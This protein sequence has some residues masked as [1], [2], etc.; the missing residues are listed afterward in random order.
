MR[1]NVCYKVVSLILIEY[2]P[3]YWEMLRISFLGQ[4]SFIPWMNIILPTDI[5]INVFVRFVSWL[6]VSS[7]QKIKEN[8]M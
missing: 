4:Q 1:S 6:P 2:I 5:M 7:L 8:I 3:Y